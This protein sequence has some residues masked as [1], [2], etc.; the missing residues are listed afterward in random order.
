M[1]LIRRIFND[2]VEISHVKNKK[3]SHSLSYNGLHLDEERLRS[4]TIKL[5]NCRLVRNGCLIKDDLVFRNGIILDPEHVFYVEK[6]KS[7]LDIDCNNLII[8]P[9]FIDTQLNGAFG[10]DFTFDVENIKQN[11]DIVSFELLKY[12]VTA[13]CPTVVSSEPSVYAKLIPNIQRTCGKTNANIGASVL[14]IHLEGPFINE[15]KMG[16][17]E[18]SSLKTFE[19][20][21]RS[22]EDVYGPLEKLI[23]NTLIVTLAPE[24]DL[25]GEII[26][27]LSSKNIIVSLGHSMA[28]LAQGE[29]AIKYGARFITHLFNAM[30]PFHHRDPHLVGLLSNRNFIQ[31]DNIFYGI[32]SDGIHTH[33]SALNIAFK[34]HPKGK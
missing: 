25:S 8:A 26:Q 14:G 22:L 23:E 1:H 4:L 3:K 5:T 30:M 10:K 34:S 24:L 28:N 21:L 13:Y 18:L 6:K 19:N 20:G 2:S 15:K 12:G 17:H 27:F 33:P 29:N 9:G 7:D 31:Q 11:L 32:I 16:A